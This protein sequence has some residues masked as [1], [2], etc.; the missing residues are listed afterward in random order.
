MVDHDKMI[1]LSRAN[2]K[3]EARDVASTTSAKSLGSL[4][5]TSTSWSRLMSMAATRPATTPPP[6]FRMHA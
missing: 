2:K 1:D 3:V 6:P 4:P 5:R